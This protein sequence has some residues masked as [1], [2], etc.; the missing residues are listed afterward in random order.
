[1]QVVLNFFYNTP[2]FISYLG[3]STFSWVKYEYEYIGDD[4]VRV[5]F[6]EYEYEYKYILYDIVTLYSNK[7]IF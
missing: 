4:R 3:P 7:N 5:H 6:R 2:V 1:M